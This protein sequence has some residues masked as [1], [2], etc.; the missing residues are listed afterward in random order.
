MN[1]VFD[2]QNGKC[3]CVR[4]GAKITPDAS[5]RCDIIRACSSRGP[6]ILARATNL[7]VA[8]IEHVAAGL[9]VCTIDEIGRRFGIC[10]GCNLFLRA[11]Q[12]SGT[13]THGGCGCHIVDASQ[14]D[15]RLNKAAWKEQRCPHSS[16]NKWQ[17]TEAELR[18]AGHPEI[19]AH[20]KEE[21]PCP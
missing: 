17:M 21:I 9:P 1:C 8:A 14:T 16:G 3:R 20:Q 4:C 6:G 11:S 19:H 12:T 10:C 18:A 5:G 13:C 7:A 15:H 2:K